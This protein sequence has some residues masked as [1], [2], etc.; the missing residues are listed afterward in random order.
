VLVCRGRAGI[1][2]KGKTMRAFKILV[3]SVTM[4]ASAI[5]GVAAAAPASSGAPVASRWCC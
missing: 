4:A 2:L 3:V 5:L 1:F